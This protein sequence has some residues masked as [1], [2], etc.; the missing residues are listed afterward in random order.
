MPI[1][2]FHCDECN[3]E[4]EKL[5]F[6]SSEKI[7]CPQCHS[8][9]VNRILSTFAFSSGGKFKSTASFSC[10]SCSATSCSSCSSK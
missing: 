10:S 8:K 1:Y 3:H 7:F 5:V 9:K 4:F 6:H 2:E